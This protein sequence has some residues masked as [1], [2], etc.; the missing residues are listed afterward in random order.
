MGTYDCGDIGFGGGFDNNSDI[1]LG[2]GGP[3]G[4]K[5]SELSITRPKDQ[6]AGG[7]PPAELLLDLLAG[8]ISTRGWLTLEIPGDASTRYEA[9]K[10]G[11]KTQGRNHQ[12]P[13]GEGCLRRSKKRGKG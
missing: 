3:A 2:K 6:G 10:A 1:W 12:R 7:D 13:H 9:R 5:V 8:E 4:S 11:E